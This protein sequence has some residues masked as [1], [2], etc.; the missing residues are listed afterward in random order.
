MRGPRARRR[1][2]LRGTRPRS[3]HPAPQS[4]ASESLASRPG[5]HGCARALLH[6]RAPRQPAQPW[7]AIWTSSS[8]CSERSSAAERAANRSAAAR[9]CSSSEDTALWAGCSAA[10]Q[11]DRARNQPDDLSRR[12][13]VRPSTRVDGRRAG[14]DLHARWRTV[15]FSVLRAVP[16]CGAIAGML[17]EHAA[18]LSLLRRTRMRGARA[19]RGPRGHRTQ[20]QVASASGPA[21]TCAIESIPG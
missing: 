19:R 15:V 9:R 8:T 20:Q 21:A 4:A 14:A 5:A 6:C 13:A 17:A 2:T 3:S 10:L 18:R 1:L 11:L 16:R 12:C 7:P